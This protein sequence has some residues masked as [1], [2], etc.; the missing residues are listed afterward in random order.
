MKSYK[1]AFNLIT[2]DAVDSY[3]KM[4]WPKIGHQV[5]EDWDLWRKLVEVDADNFT[6]LDIA[7]NHDMWGIIEPLSNQ[8]LYLD[9]SYT[10]TRD[11]TKTLNDFAVRTINIH[12]D[13][14]ALL[15]A[16]GL[17]ARSPLT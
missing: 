9:Y 1:A 14:S 5:K 4:H 15:S 12:G 2:G 3:G 7:G 11:N 16:P 17:S 13:D 10:Y 6:I 8:N